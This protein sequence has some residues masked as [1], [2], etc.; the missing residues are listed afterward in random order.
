MIYFSRGDASVYR[1]LIVDDEVITRNG[2]KNSVDW[3]AL[4]FTVAGVCSCGHDAIR[5]L[6]DNQVHVVLTDIRMHDGSGLELAEW[7]NRNRADVLVV[8]LTGYADYAAACRA[9]ALGA[10]KFLLNK[11]MPVAD[12][13][14]IFHK[15][16]AMLDEMYAAM[17]QQ[18]EMRLACLRQVLRQA[19]HG[20]TLWKDM[21]L[22][23]IV[24]SRPG[25]VEEDFQP[26]PLQSLHGARRYPGMAESIGDKLLCL[27]PC[28]PEDAEE[29]EHLA[30]ILCYGKADAD[31]ARFDGLAPFLTYLAALMP[32][33]SPDEK[34]QYLAAVD[35]YLLAHLGSR[36]LLKDVAQQFHYSVSYFSRIF[37]AW[38]GLGFAD[39]LTQFRLEQA[40]QRLQSS[41]SSITAIASAV[42]FG[43]ARHFAHAFKKRFGMTPSAYRH[44][45]AG[46]E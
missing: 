39:Y 32:A 12:I 46:K 27:Y 5:F 7:I 44:H 41:G 43:D 38:S 4:N 30:Q 29:A 19:P 21:S 10:V 22:V 15:L 37:K 34:A 24:Q 40:Q 28:A 3:A 20:E 16:S 9:V 26:P 18:S 8:L 13:K 31:I 11:P 23:A 1:L 35:Q 36:I 17:A 25:A 2:L 6:M 33:P 42:G 14:E 45:A